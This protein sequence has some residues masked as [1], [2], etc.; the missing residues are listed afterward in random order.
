MWRYFGAYIL[1]AVGAVICK[2]RVA[3]F[4]AA[5]ASLLVF[6]LGAYMYYDMIY[7]PPNTLNDIDLVIPPRQHSVAM[8]AVIVGLGSLVVH[9]GRRRSPVAANVVR[10]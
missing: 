2:G 3:A 10:H 6:A 1:A 5:G 8:T 7:T 4:F 9:Y